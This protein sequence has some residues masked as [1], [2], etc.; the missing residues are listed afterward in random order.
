MKPEKRP[1]DFQRQLVVWADQCE[2]GE[3]PKTSLYYRLTREIEDARAA[4]RRERERNES[5]DSQ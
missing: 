3:T 1:T 4:I 5:R 2:A